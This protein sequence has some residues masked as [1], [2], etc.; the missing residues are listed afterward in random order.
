MS[1]VYAKCIGTLYVTVC[2]FYIELIMSYDWL[3]IRQFRLRLQKS[4]F[5]FSKSVKK[6]VKR[7]VYAREAREPHTPCE[8]RQ[9]NRL[10]VRFPHNEL[11]LPTREFKNV[12]ELSKICSQL[13]PLCEFDA[14]GDWFRGRIAHVIVCTWLRILTL[15]SSNSKAVALLLCE[16]K[17]VE[18]N[19]V[20]IVEDQ[21]R[22]EV[23]VRQQSL[24]LLL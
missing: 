24:C 8:A 13:R 19:V 12:V 4:R 6:S 21:K 16:M 20:Y 2:L 11:N 1:K 15:W 17:W 5:H 3:L 14:L 10:T 7:S 18:W 9:K 22:V 23:A